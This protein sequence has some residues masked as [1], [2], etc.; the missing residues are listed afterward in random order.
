[1][2]ILLFIK[3]DIMVSE[4]N[5]GLNKIM[6][7]MAQQLETIAKHPD[8]AGKVQI[9]AMALQGVCDLLYSA[10]RCIAN[11]LTENVALN[12]N[13][14]RLNYAKLMAKCTSWIKCSIQKPEA[15]QYI[16][17]V[18]RHGEYAAGFVDEEEW[19][20]MY[21]GTTFALDEIYIWLPLP[22]PLTPKNWK[23]VP[24][25]LTPEMKLQMHTLCNADCPDC[26]KEF[27][28]DVTNNIEQSWGDML[29]AAPT[30]EGEPSSGKP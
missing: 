2:A 12:T 22:P 23:L 11:L 19:V 18:S 15:N 7:A 5:D 28:V 1:M 17:F 30:A 16:S 21:D 10:E 25:R 4:F 26:G 27:A 20:E 13:T 6:L 24:S 14:D 29:A 9:G 3:V 8:D